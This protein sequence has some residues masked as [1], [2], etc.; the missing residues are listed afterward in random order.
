MGFVL[1]LVASL[2]LVTWQ[3]RAERA[4]RADADAAR[5]DAEANAREILEGAERMNEA[6]AA[7]RLAAQN[8][9]F[10]Q[11]A[12]AEAAH[13]RAIG[14]RPDHSEA[15]MRRGELYAT[16]GLWDFALRDY[17][18]SFERRPPDQLWPWSQYALLHLQQGDEAGYRRVCQQMWKRFSPP[19]D[20]FTWNYLTSV[21]AM[22][23]RSVP[24]CDPP[25]FPQEDTNIPPG[26]PW[27]INNVVG[28]AQFRA[29]LYPEAIRNF[30]ES[31]AKTSYPGRAKNYP[32]LAMA[33]YR[34][35][36]IGA[37][38]VELENSRKELDRWMQVALDSRD[39]LVLGS[40]FGGEHWAD[41][42]VFLIYHG[43]AWRLIE[44]TPPAEDPRLLVLRGRAFAALGRLDQADAEYAHAMAL[45]PNN[46]QVQKAVE[47]AKAAAQQ[48]SSR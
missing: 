29:G 45:A 46:P 42:V 36:E 3:W 20:K 19:K 43:E 8:V 2:V 44:Q 12:A 6:N 15:W 30:R 7:I 5:R 17:A 27:F 39:R 38:R 16:L 35:G 4:A 37:A 18:H 28:L 41:W 9:M 1:L 33:L 34:S 10:G 40:W 11:W 22:V 48:S 26:V 23:P 21:R 25:A 31:L 14:Q 24:G 32:V 47:T 13:G